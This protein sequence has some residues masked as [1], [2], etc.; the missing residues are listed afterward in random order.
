MA[1]GSEAVS[2]ISGSVFGPSRSVSTD[3]FQ[4][5]FT[6]FTR[7]S[8]RVRLSRRSLPPRNY[9][10]REDAETLMNDDLPTIWAGPSKCS[11]RRCAVSQDPEVVKWA[12]KLG[13]VAVHY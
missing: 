12:I 6:I 9:I 13:V 7:K 5:V 3:I 1:Q 10:L 4:P 11:R 2:S 8:S